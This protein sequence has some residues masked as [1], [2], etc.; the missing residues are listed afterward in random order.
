MTIAATI[1][2]TAANL[3]DEMQNGPYA[4]QITA[5]GAGDQAIANLL[6][7]KNGTANGEVAHGDVQGNMLAGL[8]DYGEVRASISG[9]DALIWNGMIAASPVK[10][11]SVNV[12]NFINAVFTQGSFPNC[13]AALQLY[14]T[15]T[16]SRT[17]VVFGTGESVT[18]QQVNIARVNSGTVEF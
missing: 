16:G 4:T 18:A 1:A 9:N 15:Q 6:N 12:Q 8:L 7:D 14:Y 10:I 17:E 5:L 2:L 13:R 3:W 11:G